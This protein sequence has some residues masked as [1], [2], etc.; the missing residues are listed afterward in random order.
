MIQINAS[1]CNGCGTCVE[2]CPVQGVK[3]VNDKAIANEQCIDCGTC[4]TS[5]PTEAIT[6]N[7]N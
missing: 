4:V 3:I 7:E 6:L 1:K 2:I 5:C